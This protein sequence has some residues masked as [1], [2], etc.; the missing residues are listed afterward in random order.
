MAINATYKNNYFNCILDLHAIPNLY[1]YK[2]S[3]L[4]PNP[5]FLDPGQTFIAI[6]N[7]VYKSL[8]LQTAYES[9]CTEINNMVNDN[10]KCLLIGC[11]GYLL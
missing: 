8:T 2:Y 1:N 9:R 4:T 6:R 11:G 3:T 7:P 5:A 10:L